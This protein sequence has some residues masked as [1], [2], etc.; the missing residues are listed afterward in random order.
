MASPQMVVDSPVVD[1]FTLVRGGLIYN[2][3][4]WLRLVIRDP[5]HVWDRILI[6]WAITWVPLLCLSAIQGLLSG[7]SVTIPF[8]FDYATNIRFLITLPL[9]LYAQV[10][11]DKRTKEAVRH[12]VDSGL[13][14]NDQLPAYEDVIQRTIRL[15]DSRVATV[16]LIVIA[17]APSFLLRGLGVSGEAMTTW[18]K[19]AL[20]TS[21]VAH[22]AAGYYAIAVSM[23]LFRL[24]LFRWLWLMA[25]WGTFLRR[26]TR[27]PLRC[28][29]THPDGTGGLGFLGH[30]QLFFGPVVFAASAVV[31]GSFANLIFHQGNSVEA[32]KFQM[33]A[34]CVFA[35]FVSISP[36]LLVTP[37]L[38]EIKEQGLYDY[39]T[40]G[41]DYTWQ[42]DRKWIHREQLGKEELLGTSDIQS[43][44]DLSNSVTVARRM[45][46]L[47][48]DREILIGL[49]APAVFPMLVLSATA[50]PLDELIKALM[51]LVG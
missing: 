15:R 24:L 49:A 32:L 1:R 4:A 20:D 6:A 29:P 30:T 16:V 8:L 45:S 14:S 31:A 46:V 9:L 28:V 37:R 34:F 25:V 12:F 7:Q 43:L 44:A 19:P 42:F 33:I 13:I 18:S 21:A 17:F 48:L 50:V 3:Q 41:V 35:V 23:P 5:K 36:L 38:F 40:L 11:I 51:Q 47:L 10:V 2:I 39:H 27:L 26:A 22:S